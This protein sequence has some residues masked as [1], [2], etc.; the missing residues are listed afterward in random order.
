MRGG[1]AQPELCYRSDE[2][3]KRNGEECKARRRWLR[4]ERC[5]PRQDRHVVLLSEAAAV[6]CG[7]M[8]GM[9][10]HVHGV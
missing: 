3:E 8:G 6:E 4:S 1:D 5:V 9:L 2:S 10:G 7:S